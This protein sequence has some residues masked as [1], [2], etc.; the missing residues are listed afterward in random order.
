MP[1]AWISSATLCLLAVLHSV[2][3]ERLLLR[4]LFAAGLGPTPIGPTLARRTLR[5]AWHLTS[6]AWLALAWLAPRLRPRELAAVGVA[7][8]ASGAIALV[9]ARGRHFA[10]ALFVVGGAAA[11]LGPHAD[12]VAPWA[13]A[14][15][16]VVLVAVAVA[17]VAWAAGSRRGLEGAVPTVDG[18]PVF[19]PSGPLTVA[20]AA[21]FAAAGAL[22]LYASRAGGA[23]A[24]FACG[25]GAVVLGARAIGDFRFVGLTK[26]ERASLF[27]RRDDAYYTPLCVGLAV[28]F[29]LVSVGGGR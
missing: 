3:G 23:W 17:H 25:A 29:A 8:L 7:L 26:R 9:A 15:A 13:G 21:G 1:S 20:V 18:R 19:R 12:R 4:P 10:W 16:G 14:L 5:F 27:A 6:V 28:C 24:S 22:V 11:V 2:L